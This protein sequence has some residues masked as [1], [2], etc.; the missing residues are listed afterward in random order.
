MQKKTVRSAPTRDL[1]VEKLEHYLNSP[2]CPQ[3]GCLPGE[4]S[5]AKMCGV[6]R[7][8]LRSA[9]DILAERG[10]VD[11]IR[12]KGTFK[13]LTYE[14]QKKVIYYFLPCADYEKYAG[15]TSATHIMETLNGLMLAT[16]GTGTCIVPLHYSQ[17]N[18]PDDPD[19][20]VLNMIEPGAMVFIGGMWYRRCFSFLRRR[21]CKVLFLNMLDLSIF[22]PDN[23]PYMDDINS[24]H[25]L[26]IDNFTGV[27]NCA[28]TLMKHGCRKLFLAAASLGDITNPL[29]PGYLKSGGKAY[30]SCDQELSL[31]I[32]RDE[33]ARQY[34]K[35][36]FDGLILGCGV[37]FPS[38]SRFTL[39]RYLGLPEEVR[40]IFYYKNPTVLALDRKQPYV[41]CDYRRICR[42]GVEILLDGYHPEIQRRQFKPHIENLEYL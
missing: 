10:V 1:V 11:R 15:I 23:A 26:R 30:W 18:R 12:G 16:R 7:K 17:S 19:W 2:E 37:E 32:L 5:L 35:F 36:Q 3:N 20:E 8:T 25:Q 34:R 13:V 24:F 38:D 39:R 6:S 40:L 31:D 42:E 21:S 29:L 33:L 28:D 14:R 22:H 41:C 27:R 4:D 9:L